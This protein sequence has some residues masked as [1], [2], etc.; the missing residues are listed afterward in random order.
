MTPRAAELDFKKA[1]ALQLLDAPAEALAA[2]Q[3]AKAH[4][5]AHLETVDAEVTRAGSSGADVSGAVASAAFASIL[6]GYAA[7]AAPAAAP[8]AAASEDSKARVAKLHQEAADLRGTIDSINDRIEELSAAVQEHISMKEQLANIFKAVAAEGGGGD[9]SS[10]PVA[11]GSSGGGGAGVT[12]TIGFGV[13]AGSSKAA[14]GEV[15]DIGVIGR[16]RRVAPTPM[17]V[18]TPA[19]PAAAA[20]APAAAEAGAEG[21]KQAAPDQA[22]APAGGEVGKKRALSDLSS[23]DQEAAAEGARGASTDDAAAKLAAA[24]GAQQ[25]DA[26]PKRARV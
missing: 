7:P 21:S 19:A 20:S 15:K 8:D 13:P 23:S 18:E 9:G 25:P 11:A 10:E 22:A 3:S 1:T 6:S 5:A 2:M 24:A 12:E 26:A 4:L 16:G 14:A 17:Q